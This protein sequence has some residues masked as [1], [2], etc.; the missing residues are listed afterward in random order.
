M[1]PFDHDIALEKK[2]NNRFASSIAPNWSVNNNPNGGYLM[3]MM[4]N[5]VLQESKK[6][7]IAIF[8][9]NFVTRCT[10]GKTELGVERVGQSKTFDRWQVGLSQ[11]GQTKVQAFCTLTDPVNGDA[12]KRYETTPPKLPP[13]NQ[14]FE[15]PQLPGYAIYSSMDVRLDP[16]NTGWLTNG[17]LADRSDM[18]GWIR[19]REDRPFDMLSVLLAA[20]AFPPPALVS[21]GMV[22]WVP[23]IEMSV[24]LRNLPKSQWLKC[25]FSSRFINNGIV[26]EDGQIWDETDELVA[27]SRQISQF[28]KTA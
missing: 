8:T 15:F 22:A 1:H 14:C 10:P 25:C 7:W 18:R 20:D 28:R 26:E 24:N 3:A 5:A 21:Q 16:V 17:D 13:Q 12:Q 2:G 19:F 4:A 6:P 23:T 9:A 11:D 27:I